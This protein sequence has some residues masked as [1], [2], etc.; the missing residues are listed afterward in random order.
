MI[1]ID[2]DTYLIE[3]TRGD[4]A[5]IEFTAEDDGGGTYLAETGDVLKFAVG[6]RRNKDYIFQIENEFGEFAAVTPTQAEYEADPTSYFT[7]SGTTYTRCT[8]G[9]AYD[10]NEHYYASTFWDIEIL[11][12]HT[13][14]LKSMLYVWDLQITING[15][16]HTIIGETD[17]IDPKFKIWGEVSQ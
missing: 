16:I 8:A 4:N 17:S 1:N 13:E 5:V 11:P 7:L 12:E 9:D 3:L 2:T 6:K 14:E 15:E 10:A